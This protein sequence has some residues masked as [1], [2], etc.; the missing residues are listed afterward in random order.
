MSKLK[1]IHSE[2]NQFTLRLSFTVCQSEI[3]VLAQE[4]SSPSLS[5]LA[6]HEW[7]TRNRGKGMVDGCD[8][9]DYRSQ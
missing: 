7:H 3:P 6:L 9:G 8:D 4:S 5:L 1:C 2:Q